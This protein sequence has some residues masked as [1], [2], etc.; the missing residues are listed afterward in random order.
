MQL[1]IITPESKVF[2]GEVV[3]V[4][5][6]GIDGL[7]Q[8]LNNHAPIISALKEGTLKIELE[9]PFERT[10]KTNSLIQED[11]NNK[12]I[13]VDIKGGVVEMTNNK[14]IVLAE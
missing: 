1:D 2:N 4:L 6:P 11:K 8:I 3:S 14:I 13:R 9:K 10:E 12:I 7:F 5:L